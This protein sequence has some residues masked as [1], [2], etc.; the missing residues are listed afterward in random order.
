MIWSIKCH[1]GDFHGM[2]M[3]KACDG[4]S[5]SPELMQVHSHRRHQLPNGADWMA[6][7]SIRKK[8]DMKLLDSCVGLLS[9]ASTQNQGNKITP[10]YSSWYLMILLVYWCIN[11]SNNSWIGPANRLFVLSGCRP[12]LFSSS[13]S[14]RS[15]N[16]R[17]KTTKGRVVR[18]SLVSKI[19]NVANGRLPVWEPSLWI[20]IL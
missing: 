1:A 16:E 10:Q 12:R 20:Y 17:D 11:N 15:N 9:W 3:H 6:T 19:S 8:R 5:A 4:A 14:T 2:R 7:M 13:K 18:K